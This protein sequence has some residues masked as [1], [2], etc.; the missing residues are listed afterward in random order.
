MSDLLFRRALASDLPQIIRM[1]ADDPLGQQRE[2]V[3]DPPIA[4][5]YDA[6]EAIEADPNQLLIVVEDEEA[7]GGTVI[8]VLQLTLIPGIAHRGAWR[9]QIEG[10][11]VASNRRS[12]GI[13][14]QM[15]EWAVAECERRGCRIVQ[16]TSNKKRKDAHRFYAR[17]GFT[18]THEGYKREL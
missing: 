5:Y 16:L 18:A 13:G 2:S 4:A 11:R 15:I 1:L 8:G 17:L 14:A 9:G 6:F 12:D 7:N 10:V 3:S